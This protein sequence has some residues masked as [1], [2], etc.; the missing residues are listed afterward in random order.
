MWVA[1]EGK[2]HE[3]VESRLR[4]L[5]FD[6]ARHLEPANNL[7]DLDI[8]EMGGMKRFEAIEQARLDGLASRRMQQDF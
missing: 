6:L 5:G 2:I 4:A 7:S 1:L 8:E 3:V